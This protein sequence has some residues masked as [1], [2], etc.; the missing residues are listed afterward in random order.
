MVSYFVQA[1]PPNALWFEVSTFHAIDEYL[2]VRGIMLA[3]QRATGSVS[4]RAGLSP[5]HR[6]GAVVG[7]VGLS[8]FQPIALPSRVVSAPQTRR[9]GQDADQTGQIYGRVI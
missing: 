1:N 3:R 5:I 7:S 8:E 2:V 4:R 9:L 6:T